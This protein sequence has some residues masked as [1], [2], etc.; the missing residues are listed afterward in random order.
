M[1]ELSSVIQ[2]LGLS[3]TAARIYIVLLELG[4]ASADKIAKKA[5]TYKANVY[6]ANEKLKEVGLIT[7]VIEGNKKLF[8]ATNPAKIAQSIDDLRE[9]ENRRVEEL[10]AD[11]AR[12]MPILNAKYNS[13]KEKEL[14]EIYR[15]HKA[16]KALMNEIF[17]E[18]P[19]YWKG[20]G[21]LQVQEYFPYDF[22]K[23][24]KR[25][26]FLLFSTDSKV[27]QRR[28]HEAKKI[29]N[30]HIK[31]LPPELYMPVV[32]TLFGKNLLILIYEPD[33]IALRIKSSQVVKTFSNQFDYL[34]YKVQRG[35][36]L[37]EIEEITERLSREDA[38]TIVRKIKRN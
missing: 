26:E 13:V 1:D 25:V 31:Y 34:W 22:P 10:K 4:K 27:F 11:I 7:E 32:W 8:Y 35:D 20:F 16:F 37:K 6:E 14:F 9:R 2:K 21:N 29:T 33:I 12:I 30:V 17:K 5:G 19:A 18:R 36:T 28:L 38:M 23:W 15:G 3:G 24:F